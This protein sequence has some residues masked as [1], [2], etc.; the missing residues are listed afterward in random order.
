MHHYNALS[1]KALAP[2]TLQPHQGRG[3][4]PYFS[5]T[6]SFSLFPL[7]PSRDLSFGKGD[8]A[9]VGGVAAI[10]MLFVADVEAATKKHHYHHDLV[11]VFRPHTQ[12]FGC[13]SEF[14]VTIMEVAS[15]CGRGFSQCRTKGL[16]DMPLWVP[17]VA[18]EDVERCLI[19]GYD[20]MLFLPLRG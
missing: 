16:A 4:L 14:G 1:E 2:H 10:A 3:H 15:L 8:G 11:F 19:F 18:G 5:R 20:D 17:S 9:H 13:S 12:G 7:N 6:S